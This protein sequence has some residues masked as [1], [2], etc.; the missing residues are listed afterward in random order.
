M[1]SVIDQIK[2]RL[3]ILYLQSPLIPVIKEFR[4]TPVVEK[5]IGEAPTI[6]NEK[7]TFPEKSLSLSIGDIEPKQISIDAPEVDDSFKP[8]APQSANKKTTAVFNKRR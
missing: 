8:E 1:V 2:N 4:Q 3:E 5:P 7:I 6:R